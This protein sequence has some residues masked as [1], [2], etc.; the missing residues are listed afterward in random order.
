MAWQGR[1]GHVVATKGVSRGLRV[2]FD[3]AHVSAPHDP[4]EGRQGSSLLDLVRSVRV[5]RRVIQQTMAHLGELVERGRLEARALGRHLIALPNTRSFLTMAEIIDHLTVPVR[6]KGV[7]IER[8]R[9]F[10]DAYLALALWFKDL[11]CATLT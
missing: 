10:G 6:L 3:S 1:F 2:R 5:G 8:S 4:Q 11:R 7:A 9:R